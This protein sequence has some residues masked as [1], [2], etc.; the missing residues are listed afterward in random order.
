MN[1]QA[2]KV[3]NYILEHT[4]IQSGDRIVV[5]LSGG[6]DSV[7]LLLLLAELGEKLGYTGRREPFY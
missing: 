6:A 1:T 2:D 5:G 4:M 3:Y 7:S